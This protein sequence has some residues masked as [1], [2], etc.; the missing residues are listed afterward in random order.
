MKDPVV[1]RDPFARSRFR[2]CS[3]RY[4]KKASANNPEELSP[5]ANIKRRADFTDQGDWVNTEEITKDIWL[6]EE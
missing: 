6:I 4:G 1:T 3:L 5:W 2:E